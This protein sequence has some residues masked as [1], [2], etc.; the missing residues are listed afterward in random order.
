[1]LIEPI[2]ISFNDLI[3]EKPC[4]EINYAILT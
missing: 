2:I 3:Y 4:Q 1:M